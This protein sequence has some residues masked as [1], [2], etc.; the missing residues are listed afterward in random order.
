MCPDDGDAYAETIYDDA[1]LAT[2][3]V[4]IVPDLLRPHPA[5]APA[6]L[7]LA[8]WP[9]ERTSIPLRCRQLTRSDPITLLEV[10]Q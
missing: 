5:M 3:G 8:G 2:K 10:Q 6:R 4:T 7:H 9:D 1:W